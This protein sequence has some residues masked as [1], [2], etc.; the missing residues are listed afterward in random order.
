MTSRCK[1][2]WLLA[3]V[4]LLPL[5]FF[6]LFPPRVG[7]PLYLPLEALLRSPRSAPGVSIRGPD[8]VQVP[9]EVLRL[10][11]VDRIWIQDTHIE[12]LPTWLTENTQ[13]GE[14]RWVSSHLSRVP[15]ALLRMTHL[16]K[17]S[18][19]RNEITELPAGIGEMTSL[20]ELHL[21]VNK[22]SRVPAQVGRLQ[23]LTSLWLGGNRLAEL[24]PEIGALTNLEDLEVNGN[25][26]TRLPPEI[27]RLRRLVRL[28]VENNRLTDYPEEMAGLTSL[29]YLKTRGNPLSLRARERLRQ[30]LPKA[31]IDFGDSGGIPDR[32]GSER[33][34]APGPVRTG[35]ET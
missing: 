9:E 8:L 25:Q 23:A 22:L 12:D 21:S 28:E 15:S 19:M 31:E 2:L 27:G 14:I 13:I 1:R 33:S 35:K 18:L 11:H 10:T 32:G 5:I 24:P 17:L 34:S 29:K 6:I 20:R 4:G 30:L 16:K 26:L 3:T 7:A